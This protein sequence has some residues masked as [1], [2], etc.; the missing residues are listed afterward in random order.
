MMRPISISL[1]PNTESD[2]VWQAFRL[3]FLPWKWKK[4]GA[5]EQLERKF[6]S[7]L[8]AKSAC[9]FNSGRSALLAIL[10]SLGLEKNGEVLLQAFTCNAVA[11]P[12]VWAGLQP[13]Y[14]DC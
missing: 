10:E 12:V 1:S 8:G 5:A 11:H 7:C 13:V 6:A 9:A 2:D 14:V 3:L 4:G